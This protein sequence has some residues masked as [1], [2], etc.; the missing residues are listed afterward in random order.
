MQQALFA[1]FDRYHLAFKTSLCANNIVAHIFCIINFAAENLDGN[2]ND[3]RLT[4][5]Y[6]RDE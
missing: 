5:V 2:I 4:Y 3:R 1:Y 6:I